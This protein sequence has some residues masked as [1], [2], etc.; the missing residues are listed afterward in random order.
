MTNDRALRVEKLARLMKD[1]D[2]FERD[3]AYAEL[4]SEVVLYVKALMDRYFANYC[5]S[6][7]EDICQEGYLAVCECLPKFDY[8]KGRSLTTYIKP[9]V[10]HRVTKYISTQV[11]NRTV[12]YS[13]IIR[14][15][16]QAE[17]ELEADG[18]PVTPGNICKYTG[19]SEKIVNTASGIRTKTTKCSLDEVGEGYG[20]SI[21]SVEEQILQ[22]EKDEA[23]RSALLDL[24]DEERTEIECFF[25]FRAG[26]KGAR[27]AQEIMG[28]SERQQNTIH[29]RAVRKLKKLR[30][31]PEFADIFKP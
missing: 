30:K 21:P 17:K 1:G 23:L 8:T 27:Y 16:K 10:M 26:G 4:L 29:T 3:K 5:V 25:G 18:T 20:C 9:Y 2:V 14:V 7:Y 28:I 15:I 31:D 6:W 24:T 13:H 22:G 19:L 12:Y 11:H